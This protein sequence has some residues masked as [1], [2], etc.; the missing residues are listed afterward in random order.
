[1]RIVASLSVALLVACRSGGPPAQSFHDGV[2]ALCDLPDHVPAPT[3]DSFEKRLAVVS[4]W[5]EHNITNAGAQAIG[6]MKSVGANRDALAAA[7]AKASIQRCRLLDNGMQLQSFN[8]AIA[9]ICDASAVAPAY[10]TSH[11]LNTEVIR[12]FKSLGDDNPAERATRLRDALTRAGRTSCPA[13]QGQSS[14]ANL[15]APT[16][17]DV[18]LVELGTNPTTTITS[19]A[20]VIEGKAIVAVTN[21][22]VDAGEK[23]GG[24]MGLEIPRVTSFVQALAKELDRQGSSHGTTF[25]LDPAGSPRVM[26]LIVDPATPYRLLVEAMSSIKAGGYSALMIAVHAGVALKA[27]PIVLPDKKRPDKKPPPPQA[28]EMIVSIVNDKVLL[29]SISGI[30]GTLSKPAVSTT[31][32]HLADVQTALA[33]IVD[34]HWHGG[35]RTPEDRQII[36]MADA[37]MALQRVAELIAS[38]RATADGKELFPSVLLST[39]FE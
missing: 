11:L 2:Q 25:T 7:V 10:F 13:M 15:K 19:S 18:G 5:A 27:I 34:K 32:D 4:D 1:M 39:G 6:G 9:T 30:E 36:V 35:K 14:T 17:P 21:G 8:D 3:T 33:A 12:L 37:G 22:D 29:W 28:L 16:V 31:P 23:D 38:V 26:T 24:A 20:I